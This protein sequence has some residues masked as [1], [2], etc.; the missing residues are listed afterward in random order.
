[1]YTVFL[2]VTIPPAVSSTLLRQM[3]MGCLTCAQIWVCAVNTKGGGGG[4]GGGELSTNKSAQELTRRDRKNCPPPCPA[5]GLNP[6]C[7]DFNS[8]ALTTELRSSPVTRRCSRSVYCLLLS[9]LLHK[10]TLY[11]TTSAR[12]VST[13]CNIITPTISTPYNMRTPAIYTLYATS[14]YQNRYALWNIRSRTP[15]FCTLR[16]ENNSA[17]HAV[18]RRVT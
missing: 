16:H 14:G 10:T 9:L 11:D 17:L 3:D 12:Q 5:R 8:D 15:D 4:W 2:Y 1:M 6:G 18:Q 7:S 13:L